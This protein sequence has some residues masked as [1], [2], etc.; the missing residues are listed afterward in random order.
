MI[1]FHTPI[2][3]HSIGC[4]SVE[5]IREMQRAGVEISDDPRHPDFGTPIARTRKQKLTALRVA[6]YVE[7]K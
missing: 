7:R 6:G 3:L 1:E 2:H 4:T 5:Q